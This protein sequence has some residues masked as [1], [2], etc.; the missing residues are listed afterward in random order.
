MTFQLKSID[1]IMAEAKEAEEEL[2]ENVKV[3]DGCIVINVRY[4]YE[5]DLDRCDTHEKILA[6]MLHLSGKN[7]ATKEVLRRFANLAMS[8]NNLEA[9][10]HN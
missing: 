5:V 1:E 3:E 7:W 6:W 10:L 8:E 2:R 4:P 9:P